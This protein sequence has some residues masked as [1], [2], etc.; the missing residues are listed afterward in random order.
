MQPCIQ[1]LTSTSCQVS[2]S[3]TTRRL[4]RFSAHLIRCLENRDFGCMTSMDLM[5]EQPRILEVEV[6]VIPRRSCRSVAWSY[7]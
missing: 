3:R 2:D 1:F 4:S 7:L 6:L 5:S